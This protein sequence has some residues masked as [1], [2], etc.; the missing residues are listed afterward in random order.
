MFVVARGGYR[1]AV[2]AAV[3][4]LAACGARHETAAPTPVKGER[5][6][7]RLQ[8]VPDLKPVAA[9]VTSR[10]IAEARARIG[11]TIVKLNVKE[12][13]LVRRGQVIAVVADDRIGLETQAYEAQVQAASAQNVNAQAELTRTRDLYAYGVYSKSRLDQVEAAAKAASGALSAARAQ[14]A[15]SAERGAQGAIIAP[16]DGRVLKA[17][18]PKGTVVV[19]GQ[20]VATLTSGPLVL[21]VEFPRRTPPL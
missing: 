18:V 7:M 11:G 1:A 4:V 17:D 21:R 12:G 15:A 2:V 20:S 19:P 5:Y 16:S 8:T 13:D 9:T 14:R 10:D 3:A 6:V